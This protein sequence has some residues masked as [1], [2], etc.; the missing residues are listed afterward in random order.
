MDIGPVGIGGG[1]KGVAVVNVK[2]AGIVDVE[3]TGFGAKQEVVEFGLVLFSFD[4]ATGRIGEVVDEYSGLRE[5]GRS[6]HP[7]ATGVHGLTMDMVRGKQLD[8]ARVEAMLDRA[9]L[10]I[11]HNAGFDRGFV[12]GLFKEVSSKPWCCSMWGIDW[13]GKGFASKGLQNLLQD[14]G[15]EVEC[16]HRAGTDV[17]ALLA[18]LSCREGYLSELLNSARPE[19]IQ[20][21]E[22]E[23]AITLGPDCSGS[24][25]DE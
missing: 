8:H 13:K 15:I 23:V 4:A 17:K 21:A 14:H 24:R 11:A 16:A 25:V 3:T 1:P 18:L 9:E 2:I 22:R 19:R 12:E 20:Q 6:I 5:P 7:A 10:L